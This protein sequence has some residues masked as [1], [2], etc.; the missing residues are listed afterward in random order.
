MDTVN[1]GGPKESIRVCGQRRSH[2]TK[3]KQ[4]QTHLVEPKCKLKSKE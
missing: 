2:G 3:V 1:M 4:K